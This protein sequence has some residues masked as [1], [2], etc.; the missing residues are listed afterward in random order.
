MRGFNRY[1]SRSAE[2]NVEFICKFGAKV[3]DFCQIQRITDI[4]NVYVSQPFVV[5][6]QPYWWQKDRSNIF[7]QPRFFCFDCKLSINN[8]F[9]F[10]SK[11]I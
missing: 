8:I 6:V 1:D 7:K 5:E 11:L 10:L 2:N 4:F 9:L 3:F